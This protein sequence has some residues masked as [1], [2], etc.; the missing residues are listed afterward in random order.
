MWRVCCEV[1]H[2]AL[3]QMV[4]ILNEALEPW[5]CAQT[6]DKLAALV[7]PP[8]LLYVVELDVDSPPGDRDA[9]YPALAARMATVD[10]SRLPAGSGGAVIA[11]PDAV[12]TVLCWALITGPVHDALLEHVYVAP[13]WRGVGLGSCLLTDVM[14]QWQQSLALADGGDMLSS[15]SRQLDLYCK[16]S[17]ESFYQRAGFVTRREANGRL[18]MRYQV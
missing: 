14:R 18:A 3:D 1:D 5:Q 16:P 9:A 2:T 7:A 4:T 8:A 10:L 17:L 13:S 15:Q 11:S 6:T 12:P